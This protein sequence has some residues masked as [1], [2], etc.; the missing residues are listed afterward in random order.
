MINIDKIFHC[1]HLIKERLR[2]FAF[3]PRED[4]SSSDVGEIL[5]DRLIKK[6]LIDAIIFYKVLLFFTDV[7]YVECRSL[8]VIVLTNAFLLKKFK[9]PKIHIFSLVLSDCP[10]QLDMLD[11]P[12]ERSLNTSVC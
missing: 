3:E 11:T 12:I 7:S 1:T 5:F 9:P 6:P 4:P 8:T 2:G 10:P